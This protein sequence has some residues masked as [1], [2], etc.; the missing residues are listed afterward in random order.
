M[1][2][3]PI[4]VLNMVSFLIL[5]INIFI[6]LYLFTNTL[7]ED[8][9]EEIGLLIP[10][11]ML[12]IGSTTTITFPIIINSA[13]DTNRTYQ[14]NFSLYFIFMIGILS[15]TVFTSMSW[16]SGARNKNS[17]SVTLGS[18]FL[19]IINFLFLIYYFYIINWSKETSSFIKGKGKELSF[20]R[21]VA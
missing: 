20:E 8:L 15:L 14:N 16:Y 10:S 6:I 3:T 17:H 4:N 12:I 1:P 21:I 5:L 19:T 2:P 11:V 9:S 7:S 13:H 18:M